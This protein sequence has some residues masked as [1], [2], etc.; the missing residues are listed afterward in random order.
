[1]LQAHITWSV[2]CVVDLFSE[3]EFYSKKRSV[4]KILVTAEGLY[5]VQ[6]IDESAAVLPL[7]SKLTVLSICFLAAKFNKKLKFNKKSPGVGDKMPGCINA[8]ETRL[9]RPRKRVI[10]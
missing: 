4:M 5:V 10:N 8:L 1:M 7:N 9:R 2:V 6:S 3:G